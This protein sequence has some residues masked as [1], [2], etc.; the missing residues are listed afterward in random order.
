[1]L[2]F[3]VHFKFFDC[4]VCVQT[5]SEQIL[6][7]LDLAYQYHSIPESRSIDECRLKYRIEQ[8]KSTPFVILSEQA[9]P[10]SCKDPSTCL[11]EFEQLMVVALQRAR[12]E[13]FFIHCAVL[14]YQ[15][16][17]IALVASSGAGK[18]TTSWG[19]LHHGF[20]YLT[21][22]M[23][24]VD[25]RSLHIDCLTHALSLKQRPTRYALPA[26]TLYGSRSLL[27]P[28]ADLPGVFHG[29][30]GRLAK[31]FYIQYDA[32]G[33]RASA[34]P[35]SVAESC[36]RLYANGLNQL[37]HDNLGLD[38]AQRIAESVQSY[39]VVCT[40]LGETSRL[41]RDLCA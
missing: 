1:M 12:P 17:F 7:A 32:Q 39:R 14:E 29:T 20:N 16:Q 6:Q 36:A 23:C 2:S 27:V 15:G 35:I 37:V 34:E 38:P 18:S 40:E 8:A 9:D 19:L 22:E 26:S 24:A 4:P 41:L 31:I 21:D 3:T 28:V 11:F 25:P 10:V 13:A 30:P 5:D 33:A